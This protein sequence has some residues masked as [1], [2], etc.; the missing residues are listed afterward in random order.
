MPW[1]LEKLEETPVK[2]SNSLLLSSDLP[3]DDD[4]EEDGEYDP[5]KDMETSE[6]EG[7]TTIDGDTPGALQSSPTSSQ[8]SSVDTPK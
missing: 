7:G 6:D 3:D 5:S 8:A 2:S 1:V 4:E